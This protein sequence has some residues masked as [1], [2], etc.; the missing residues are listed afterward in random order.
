MI[1]T[2]MVHFQSEDDEVGRLG[3]KLMLFFCQS[4]NFLY[5]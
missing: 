2:L 4:E 5:I 1:R 3:S